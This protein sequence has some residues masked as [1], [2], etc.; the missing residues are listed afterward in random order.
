VTAKPTSAP[1]SHTAAPTAAPVQVPDAFFGLLH[2]AGAHAPPPR[3]SAIVTG[4]TDSITL[5]GGVEATGNLLN[6]SWTFVFQNSTWTVRSCFRLILYFACLF[7][8]FLL[9]STLLMS[10][11]LLCVFIL[12]YFVFFSFLSLFVI[13]LL[14]IFGSFCLIL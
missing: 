9:C 5:Y 12:I 11:L 7:N 10:F 6:D 2:V 8:L 13:H 4:D 3:S 1:T 14:L